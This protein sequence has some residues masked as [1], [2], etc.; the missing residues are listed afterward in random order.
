MLAI[1]LEKSVNESNLA[2]NR[3]LKYENE[4]EQQRKEIEELKTLLQKA[5][6]DA[7]ENLKAK[8]QKYN[9]KIRSLKSDNKNL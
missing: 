6:V 8:K 3:A 5:T 2:A 4:A 7:E 9:A 1:E